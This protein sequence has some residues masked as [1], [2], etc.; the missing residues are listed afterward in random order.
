MNKSL[1]GSGN[2]WLQ[3]IYLLRRNL[4]VDIEVG[5]SLEYKKFHL[6][7]PQ[8]QCSMLNTQVHPRVPRDRNLTAGCEAAGLVARRGWDGRGFADT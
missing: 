5:T 7:E 6:N 4:I 2:L 8:A 3:P 1:H